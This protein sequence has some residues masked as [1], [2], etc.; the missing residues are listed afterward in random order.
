MA[1]AFTVVKN[2]KAKVVQNNENR[3]L[4]CHATYIAVAEWLALRKREKK[5]K[6]I[7]LFDTANRM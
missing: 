6:K 2:S 7:R 1:G 3:A 5:S 4:Y